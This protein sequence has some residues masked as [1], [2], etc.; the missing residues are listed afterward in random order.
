MPMK[1]TYILTLLAL[2]SSLFASAYTLPDELRETGLRTL[3]VETVDGEEPEGESIKAPAGCWGVGLTNV[4]KVP[5]SLVILNPDGSVDFESGEYV[6]KESG[7]TIK[8]RGN[9]SAQYPKKPYKIKLEKK[10]D[11][12]CRG[13]KSLNDKNWVLL[14]V[15]YNLL[16]LGFLL[17]KWIGMPFAPEYEYVNLVLNGEYR[18]VYTLAESVERNEKCRIITN[19]TGF[20]TEKDCYWWNE[21]GEYFNSIWSTGFNWT[22]KYPDFEDMT[23]EQKDYLQEMVTKFE[24]IIQT[25]QY[26]EFIDVDSFARW[27]IVHDILGTGDG[28]GTNFFL[29]KYDNTPETKLFVPV[30]WDTDSGMETEDKF[31]AVQRQWSTYYAFENTNPALKNKYIEIYRQLGDEL[32]DRLDAYT[33]ELLSGEGWEGYD[34]AAALNND[35]WGENNQYSALLNGKDME[36]WFPAR[37][38][39]HDAVVAELEATSA[40]GQPTVETAQP[41]DISVFTIDG[42]RVYYG[43]R[44][45][46]RPSSKGIYIVDGK[47]ISL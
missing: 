25:E 19:E 7:M 24:E 35:I 38:L 13:D 14:T 15:R 36:W 30:V 37:K 41:A 2:S 40:I 17:G 11:L 29:A 31:S 4:N 28:G 9:T 26:D 6:K 32:Y 33:A 43:P 23:D 20:I 27:L 46:F 42:V 34:K 47:K 10:G 21:N 8:L 18:G 16:E 44:D 3:V 39:W 1:H 12:L 45:G 22:M 5:G